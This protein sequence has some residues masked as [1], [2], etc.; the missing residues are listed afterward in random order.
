MT[1]K[2]AVVVNSAAP[3]LNVIDPSK[4]LSART[5]AETPGADAS[6]GIP[7]FIQELEPTVAGPKVFNV[8]DKYFH[9]GEDGQPLLMPCGP[10]VQVHLRRDLKPA[11]LTNS[12]EDVDAMTAF[13]VAN[14]VQEFISECVGHPAGWQHGLP[15]EIHA[16]FPLNNGGTLPN[17]FNAVDL[18]DFDG[19]GQTNEPVVCLEIRENVQ[20]P[21]GYVLS[22]ARSPIL[23]AHEVGHA[24]FNS[25]NLGS[26]S[27]LIA[28]P[29]H[30][31]RVKQILVSKEPEHQGIRT[32]FAIHEAVGDITAVLHALGSPDVVAK[33]KEETG[34]DLHQA[35]M[36]SSIGETNLAWMRLLLRDQATGVAA[37][38]HAQQ[39]LSSEFSQFIPFAR[40][41]LLNHAQ[42]H[43]GLDINK[44]DTFLAAAQAALP[45]LTE[46]TPEPPARPPLLSWIASRVAPQSAHQKCDDTRTP[47]QRFQRYITEIA[48][49]LGLPDVHE[50]T[51]AIKNALTDAMTA[52]GEKQ[53]TE[54][55]A[56]ADQMINTLVTETLEKAGPI[57][58]RQLAECH[59]MDACWNTSDDPHARSLPFS[60]AAYAVLADLVSQRMEEGAPFVNAVETARRD[61]G[62]VFYRAL[63]AVDWAGNATPQAIA[64]QIL[65]AA[66][67][68]GSATLWQHALSSRGLTPAG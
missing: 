35:N 36:V 41:A 29:E 19:D 16:E 33:V 46:E 12:Q 51:W 45:A 66:R 49:Q 42:K 62:L 58:G 1:T 53:F 13:V 27:K 60:S 50:T 8:P 14:Q 20:D 59:T 48:K 37:R 61:V 23:V 31:D 68:A 43:H 52:W 40:E 21:F 3:R 10:N 17:A 24:W 18:Q 38:Q 22:T 65:A 54:Q 15:L 28:D 47:A 32:I 26:V 4:T 57:N 56:V 2:T 11:P 55:P 67:S 64:E 44:I 39:R 63:E 5:A 30:A 34:G 6:K 25:L 9:H 7:A